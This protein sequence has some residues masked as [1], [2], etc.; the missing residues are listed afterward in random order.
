MELLLIILPF[1]IVS[2]SCTP[3]KRTEIAEPKSD[4]IYYR[5][6]TSVVPSEYL[7]IL[8]PNFIDFTFEGYVEINVA[9]VQ[10]TQNITL[11]A[12]DITFLETAVLKGNE[13]VPISNETEDSTRDF[14]ILWFNNSLET[15]EYLIKINYTGNLQ[16]QYKG[17]Y[18]SYYVNPQNVTR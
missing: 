7:L 1:L 8:A 16:S 15:G 5:L 17:F 6:P 18:R 13:A 12:S 2:T 14:H 11:H 10:K 3:I 4:G 9:V